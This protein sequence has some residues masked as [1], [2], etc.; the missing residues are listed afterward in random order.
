[1]VKIESPSSKISNDFFYTLVG[2][3]ILLQVP[4]YPK[5]FSLDIK[6][7]KN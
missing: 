4:D 3:K 2:Q 1:M 6:K 7:K 5:V